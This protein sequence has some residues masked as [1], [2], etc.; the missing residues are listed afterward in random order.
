MEKVPYC[1][2]VRIYYSTV[3]GLSNPLTQK[4]DTQNATTKEQTAS[5]PEE[6]RSKEMSHFLQS[7]L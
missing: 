4:M 2:N 3:T 5:P 6:N 7:L 1:L